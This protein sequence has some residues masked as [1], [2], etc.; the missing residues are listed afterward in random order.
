MD[1]FGFDYPKE[2][3][4][5]MG[6]NIPYNSKTIQNIQSGVCGYFCIAFLHYMKDKQLTNR[7]LNIYNDQYNDQYKYIQ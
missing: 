6:R 7:D 5:Y 2:V 4:K 1:P 3:K